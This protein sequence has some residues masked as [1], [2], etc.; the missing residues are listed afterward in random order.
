MQVLNNADEMHGSAIQT[1]KTIVD[2]KEYQSLYEKAYPGKNNGTEAEN[3]C[4]AI[5]SYERTLIA[6]NSRFDQHMNGKAV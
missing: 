4:N 1:A 5:A 2:Q 3:I 6:L